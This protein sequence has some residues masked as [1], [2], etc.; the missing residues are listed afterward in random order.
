M[1]AKAKISEWLKCYKELLFF[2][3]FSVVC[4]I[5]AVGKGAINAFGNIEFWLMLSCIILMIGAEQLGANKKLL[6]AV[7]MLATVGNLIHACQEVY[8]FHADELRAAG[9]AINVDYKSVNVDYILGFLVIVVVLILYPR[10]HKILTNDFAI[11]GMALLTFAIY[12]LLLVAGQEV[13]GVKAWFHGIQLTEP[14]KILFVFVIAGLLSK[15]QSFVRSGLAVLYMCA[16]ILC[17][18]MISEYGTLIVMGIVF[19]IF[20]FIFPN[21]LWWLGGVLLA[22]TTAVIILFSAGASIYHETMQKAPAED[23]ARTFAGEIKSVKDEDGNPLSDAEILQQMAEN[24]SFRSEFIQTFC[25]NEFWGNTVV[26]LYKQTGHGLIH[27]VK[28]VILGLY[29]KCVQRFV[30]PLFP[31]DLQEKLLGLQDLD[32][33]N[34]LYQTNQAA[35]AMR[36]GGL[37]GSGS[38]EFMKIAV[39][40]SDMVFASIVSF[41][42]FVMGLFVILMNMMLFRE[43]IRIQ[44]S[45]ETTP[46]HQGVALGLSL[47]LF[48]QAMFIIGGNM[49]IF[50]LTGITLP[51]IAAGTTSILICFSMVGLLMTLSFISV[52]EQN[53]Q[54]D[55]QFKAFWFLVGGVLRHTVHDT[56]KGVGKVY[57]WMRKDLE[58]GVID[59]SSIEEEDWDEDVRD[60][61]EDVDEDMR[62]DL[63]L[64]EDMRDDPDEEKQEDLNPDE[65]VQDDEVE[66][67]RTRADRKRTLYTDWADEGDEEDDL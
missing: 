26:A 22:G 58:K 21:K 31:V 53:R 67:R 9:K 57:E 52:T 24:E 17:L 35:R 20:L 43:G 41:F 44:R 38:H 36:I 37:T 27:K 5:E 4:A 13:G 12:G 59:D 46:F 55:N 30:I 2:L 65:D 33:S 49:G 63:D 1:S 23:F 54:A 10:F 3:L 62:D 40:E 39:M 7:F 61:N 50:P 6:M 45:L 15:K 47:M 29:N 11:L 42:G 66:I 34:V 16:N 60:E 18:G 32:N 19:L 25:Q 8:Y 28:S 48:V 14:V 56:G 64:D 51:F